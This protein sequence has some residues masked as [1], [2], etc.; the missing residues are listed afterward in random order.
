[1]SGNLS[2]ETAEDG[3][4]RILMNVGWLLGGKGFGAVCSIAYLAILARS[5]GVRDFGHFSLIFGTGLAL[6]ELSKF[7]TW[8]MVVRYGTPY[9]AQKNW[10]AFGRLAMGGMLI[11]FLSAIAG[12]AVAW[13]A[14]IYF[15]PALKLNPAYTSMAFAFVCALL[16]ARV[17]APQGV[18]RTLDRFDLA[19][20]AG[21][22]TPTARLLAALYIWASGATVAKFLLA[23]AVIEL[24]SAVLYWILAWRLAPEAVRSTNLFKLGQMSEENPGVVRFLGITYA[25]TSLLGAMQ[26]GPLLA[27]GYFLGT[28]AAG[29]Y[30]IADQLSKG[31]GKLATLSAQAL[32][33]EV[34]RQRH[35][36]PDDQFRK[37]VRQVNITVLIAGTLLVALT[38]ALG[39]SLL[40]LIGGE[41]FRKG[42][43]ILIPL[44]LAAS[45]ELAS[46]SYESVL[47][48]MGKAHYQ[49][50]ARLFTLLAMAGF[51]IWLVSGGPVW[52]G[53][54]VAFG[55][56]AGFLL[57]SFIVWRVLRS[58]SQ[59]VVQE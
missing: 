3:T 52:V 16:L 29:V 32:Y 33:P 6:V 24:F 8:Q 28:S 42:G 50:Y 35:A 9:V 25:S 10:D 57:H 45:L 44:V 1:M 58:S 7:Q 30:R 5:L 17:S 22:I 53:W 15:G 14:I 13:I 40:E 49:L 43:P 36:S 19:V 51:V 41:G 37:L 56:L 23:W 4:R 38:I 27:V 46:V 21:A 20:S 48:S 31:L 59:A 2:G 34:N 55:T 18:M 26:Q 54:A 39:S 11:D 47:H 12:S